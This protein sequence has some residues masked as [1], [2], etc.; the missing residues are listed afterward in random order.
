MDGILYIYVVGVCILTSGCFAL[1]CEG[2]DQ[3]AWKNE[4]TASN[5]K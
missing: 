3:V 2:D 5:G 1:A 4:Y